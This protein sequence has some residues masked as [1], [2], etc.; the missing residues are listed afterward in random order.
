MGEKLRLSTG[1]DGL[2]ELLGGGLLPGTLTLVVG[3][4]GI[5]KTQLGLHFAHAGM[6]QEGRPGIVF[7]MNA[8]GDSQN[9]ADYARRMFDWQLEAVE[10]ETCV[11]LENFFARDRRSGDYLHVF[12]QSG[13]RVT[14]RD[15]DF[16][17]WHDWQAE[18]TRR[19]GA[20]IAFF[21][22]NFTRGVCRAVV[23][24][25]EPADR[26]SESIQIELFEYVYHQ[27]LRKDPEWVARDLFR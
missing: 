19:I 18:L 12:D 8:R 20:T 13:R 2:D 26:P 22:G 1:I 25:I 4:T 15:L 6:A 16:D 11:D 23:D 5:G 3:S 14:R 21:Y 7:D 9:H 10:P 17:D 27:I 24:G